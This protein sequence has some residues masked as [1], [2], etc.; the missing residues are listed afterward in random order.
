MQQKKKKIKQRKPTDSWSRPLK[1]VV[2]P[3]N[4]DAALDF[5]FIPLNTE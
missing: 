3:L 1:F 5:P 4:L 2:D